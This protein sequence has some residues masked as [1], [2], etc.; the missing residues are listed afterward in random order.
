[1]L[2]ACV[3]VTRDTVRHPRRFVFGKFVCKPNCSWS[4]T[5]VNWGLTVHADRTK[6]MVMSRDQIAGWSQNMKT[7]NNSFERVEEFRYFG[8]T[9][10]NQNSIHEE[11]KSR[12]KSGN[13]CYHLV[14]SLLCSSLLSKNMKIFIYTELLFCLLFCMGLQLGPWHWGRNVGWGHLRIGCWGEYLGLRGTR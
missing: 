2:T 3:F 13:A 8:T 12:L 11:I 4:E 5:F 10:T 9:I 6:Y 7:V 14:Q 1:M